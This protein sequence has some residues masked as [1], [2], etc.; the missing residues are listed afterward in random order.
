MRIIPVT[1]AELARIHALET[2]CYRWGM[3]GHQEFNEERWVEGL[4]EILGEELVA[5]MLRRPGTEWRLIVG[6]T[7]R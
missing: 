2:T 6:E 7:L 4:E 1:F 5:L 3:S